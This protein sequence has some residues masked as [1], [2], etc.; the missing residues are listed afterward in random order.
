MR[1]IAKSIIATLLCVTLI[2]GA[3]LNT[4]ALDGTL[5]V[6]PK[7]NALNYGL[8]NPS[9]ALSCN[10]DA[11]AMF[12]HYMTTGAKCGER[13]VATAVP[14]NMEYL[15]KY[16]A[17]NRSLYVSKGLNADFAYF[18]VANY[19][20]ANPDLVPYYGTNLSLYLYHYINYGI[21]EG[22]GSGTLFDPARAIEFNAGIASLNNPKLNPDTIFLNYKATTGL[23]IT[24][25]LAA[26]FNGAGDIYTVATSTPAPTPTATA[27][28]ASSGS[29]SNS[30]SHHWIWEAQDDGTHRS[31]CDSCRKAGGQ[32]PQPHRYVLIW[33]YTDACNITH[34][35][36]SCLDCH[37]KHEVTINNN[38]TCPCNWPC[39]PPA[40]K[41]EEEIPW[42]EQYIKAYNIEIPNLF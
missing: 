20:A 15:F 32:A 39:N 7:F 19:I 14:T 31:V 38:P 1:K 28:V 25:H 3:N 23:A 16:M 18:N 5:A 26:A 22:R 9:V 37:H 21:Y 42:W 10:Y 34:Q 36:Y 33:Q 17:Y 4:F 40:T 35:K 8:L 12:N 11:T 29:S 6:S 27:T 41:E 24:S 2:F 30:C 13:F